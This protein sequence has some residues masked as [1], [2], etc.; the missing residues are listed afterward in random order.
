M[1]KRRSLL[2]TIVQVVASVG[3]IIGFTY[4][5]A[6]YIPASKVFFTD[7]AN[8]GDVIATVLAFIPLSLLI[9][10]VC[11]IFGIINLI[12]SIKQRKN[13]E[14]KD[15]FSLI[16]LIIGIILIVIP[17]GMIASMFIASAAK[18]GNAESAIRFIML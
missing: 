12:I 14:T 4:L 2:A 7:D 5:V 10:P 13:E 8:L 17:A 9:G 3:G 6:L 15:V 11:I 16:F 1:K 18:S